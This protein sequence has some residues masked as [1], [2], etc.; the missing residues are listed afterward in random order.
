MQS[1]SALDN[2]FANMGSGITVDRAWFFQSFAT[3]N[4][5]RDWTAFDHT[6]SVA[7]AHR[8]PGDPGVRQPVARLRAGERLQGRAWYQT[9]YTQPDPSGTV[10]YRDFVAEVVARYA[11][12]PTVAFWQ[13]MNEPQVTTDST[14][15]SRRT[16]NSGWNRS[17]RTSQDS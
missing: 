9:G 17:P 5:Q 15:M 12:D 6:L 8:R 10:S 4:G 13:L 16:P 14:S 3:T 2:A 7:A 11:N 1:G